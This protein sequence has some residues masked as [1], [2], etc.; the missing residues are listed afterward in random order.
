ML[1]INAWIA[2]KKNFIIDEKTKRY[3]QKLSFIKIDRKSKSVLEHEMNEQHIPPEVMRL[4]EYLRQN[5]KIFMVK[6]E[7]KDNIIILHFLSWNKIFSF[8]WK[9]GSTSARGKAEIEIRTFPKIFAESKINYGI[10]FC[11]ETKCDERYWYSSFWFDESDHVT[12]ILASVWL[13]LR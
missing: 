10:K 5:D 2:I 11:W 7:C 13:W 4:T 1:R 8:K 3:K 9:T 6:S 12:W